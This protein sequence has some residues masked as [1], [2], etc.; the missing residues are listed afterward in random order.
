MRLP[1]EDDED[2]ETEK[3]ER[4]STLKRNYEKLYWLWIT[5]IVF[6]LIVQCLR[7]ADMSSGREKFISKTHNGEPVIIAPN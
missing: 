6:D 4:I 5:I 2:Q 1:D 7:S 3:L